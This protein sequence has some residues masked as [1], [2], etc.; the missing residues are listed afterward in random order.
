MR[1]FK[2][3]MIIT[4][5]DLDS[6]ILVLRISLNLNVTEASEKCDWTLQGCCF[7]LKN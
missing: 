7:C 5:P 1:Y 4:Q 2:L 3:Y 6:F